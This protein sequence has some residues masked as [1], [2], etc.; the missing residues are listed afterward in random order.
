MAEKRTLS[1]SKGLEAAEALETLQGA[2]RINRRRDLILTL[3]LGLLFGPLG[4]SEPIS[5]DWHTETYL[6][7]YGVLLA[8]VRHGSGHRPTRGSR[9]AHPTRPSPTASWGLFPEMERPG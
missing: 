1:G 4:C 5:P 7:L 2:L 3:G 9:G 6:G 8:A